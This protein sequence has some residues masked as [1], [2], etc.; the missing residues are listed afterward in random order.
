[1]VIF[2]CKRPGDPT[3]QPETYK[4]KSNTAVIKNGWRYTI[5]QSFPYITHYCMAG[6]DNLFN[7]Q[8]WWRMKFSLQQQFDIQQK[9]N[10]KKTKYQ[11]EDT[12]WF[13]IIFSKWTLQ[14]MYTAD[15]Q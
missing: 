1:M 2:V 12:I 15:V 6:R 8:Q 3:A 11:P 10:Q 14:I 5:A 13:I 4:L 7:S 9:C